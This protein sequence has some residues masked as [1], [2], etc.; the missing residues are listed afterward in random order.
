MQLER[1]KCTECG[2][3]ME[4]G[5]LVDFTYGAALAQTW[6]SGVPQ[7]RWWGRVKVNQDQCR[8]VETDRCKAC[9]FLK[10]YAK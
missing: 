7:K 10:S 9:G 3:E 6:T 2:R 4:T 8:T 1:T 5:F